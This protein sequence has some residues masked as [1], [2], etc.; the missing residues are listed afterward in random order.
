MKFPLIVLLSF[1]YTFSFGQELDELENELIAKIDSTLLF[2]DSKV[3]SQ[4]IY[5]VGANKNFYFIY[6]STDW[7]N[8]CKNTMRLLLFDE[9]KIYLGNYYL[10]NKNPVSFAEGKIQLDGLDTSIFD[11]ASPPDLNSKLGTIKFEYE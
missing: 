11:S 3:C 2:K 9:N 5:L 8:S 7:G 10:P 4:E 6:L 1:I